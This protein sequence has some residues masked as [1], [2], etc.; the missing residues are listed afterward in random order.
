[1]EIRDVSIIRVRRTFWGCVQ[2]TAVDVQNARKLA[3]AKGYLILAVDKR[4]YNHIQECATPKEI[5][6]K[7][8]ETFEDG[9]L[10]RKVSCNNSKAFLTMAAVNN[11]KENYWYMDSCASSHMTKKDD[12]L[13][14]KEDCDTTI[15]A[16]N[17]KNLRGTA[18]GSV[19]LKVRNGSKVEHINVKEVTYVLG[20][21]AN[22]LSVSKI[23][24]KGYLVN[25]DK[26]GFTVVNE[27]IKEVTVK[28]QR[29]DGVYM[30]TPTEDKA[31]FVNTTS[32]LMWHQ[33]LGH[34]NR[35]SILKLRAK[36]AYGLN[37][38]VV[39]N[40]TCEVC[41][42][43]KQNKLPFQISGKRAKNLLDLVHSDLCGPMSVESIG[44]AKYFITFIDDHSR[45]MFLY[46]IKNKSNAYNKFKEFKALV[47]NQTGHKIKIRTDNGR[48]YLS[49]EFA[50]IL[51][52]SGIKYQTTISY[53]PQ[54]NGVAER[55][56][57][58][59][60]ERARSML[61]GADL[62]KKYWA[63][64]TSTAT[65]LI[66][67]SPSKAIR[68]KTPEEIWTGMQTDLQHLRVF[69]CIALAHIPK[70]KRVM[71]YNL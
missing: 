26:K 22:L 27:K 46:F 71:R 59:I 66:N 10:T 48:E 43:G 65:Y 63:E 16:A 15:V 28:G 24:D 69:G 12:W 19:N 25:F 60:V 67:R 70:E 34:L 58:T 44:G 6:K 38:I 36:P 47:E 14:D 45:K 8:S 53:N 5:W 1:M 52:N 20:I 42:A 4:N 55:A 50:E 61:I 2:G 51:K 9:G 17:N 30:I 54:Q 29:Q 49:N 23:T 33:R 13:K 64:A 31:L 3:K 35:R 37:E 56:N 68:E 62:P 11:I 18:K 40:E 39:S 32:D 57:R 7:L 41:V 21:A